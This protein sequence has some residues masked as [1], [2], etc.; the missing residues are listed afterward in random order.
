MSDKQNAFRAGMGVMVIGTSIVS[1][2][3]T[4]GTTESD[5]F[6]SVWDIGLFLAIQTI[7]AICIIDIYKYFRSG[8]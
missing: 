3:S 7:L 2:I 5:N 8:E 6:I 1:I 4:Y